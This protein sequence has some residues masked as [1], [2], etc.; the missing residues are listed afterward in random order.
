PLLE[1]GRSQPLC[2]AYH[3]AALPAL[4]QALS[5]KVLRMQTVVKSLE[6]AYWTAPDL[7]PFANINTPEQWEATRL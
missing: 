1:P 3:R 2:A 6:P 5:D 7:A 4:E